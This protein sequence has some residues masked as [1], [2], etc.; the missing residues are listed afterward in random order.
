MPTPPN[1]ELLELTK[2]YYNLYKDTYL[3]ATDMAKAFLEANPTINR[4]LDRVR[5][6]FRD[7]ATGQ[8]KVPKGDFEENKTIIEETKEGKFINYKGEESITSLEQAIKY[9]EVDLDIWEVEDWKCKS[10]DTSMNIKQ[11][12]KEGKPYSASIKRTNYAVSL[13]L[14]KK[15]AELDYQQIFSNID[16]QYTDYPKINSTK[17]SNIGVLTIADLH[18]GL[19]VT[20]K[21]GIINTPE[22]NLESIIR[23]LN[24]V[25]DR[26]NNLNY[27][28]V[29]LVILGDLVESVSGYNH[30]ETLK[31]MEST[32]TGG[33]III[34]AYEILSKFIAKIK[35]LK[36]VYMISGNHDRLTPMKEM[37]KDGGACQIIAY[38]LKNI[39]D[40]EWHPFLIS[41][42]IDGISYILTHGHLKI[43]SSDISKLCFEY[44]NQDMYN[45]LLSGHWHVRKATKVFPEKNLILADTSKYRAVVVPPIVSGTRWTEENGWSCAPGFIVTE[46][47]NSR[48]NIHFF[49]FALE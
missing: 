9:F 26:M 30:I 42:E 33:S 37:D 29:H 4:S 38:M 32:I 8:S 19:K 17:G 49:D 40:V 44:G 23:Y 13:K 48:R 20:E 15:V 45:V 2:G 39:V 1:I 7:L 36:K 46:A 11:L 6:Y 25:A 24:E 3:N 28:E 5:R 35:N 34:L 27:S 43:T 16:K 41:K 10:W 18:I 14:K 12:D 22:F 47:T 21:G 31:E